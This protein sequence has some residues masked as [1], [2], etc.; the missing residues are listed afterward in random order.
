M[1]EEDS[2]KEQCRDEE[3]YMAKLEEIMKQFKEWHEGVD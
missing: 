1:H 3:D 2:G